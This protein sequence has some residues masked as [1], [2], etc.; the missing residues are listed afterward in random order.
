ML[1]LLLMLALVHAVGE[2]IGIDLWSACA[3]LSGYA[4]MTMD[5][6]YD[7]GMHS[8]MCLF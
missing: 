2:I 8:W 7:L 4:H 1:V 5:Y 6:L 3:Q